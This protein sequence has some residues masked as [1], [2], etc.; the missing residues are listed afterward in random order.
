[1]AAIAITLAGCHSYDR[2]AT[3]PSA[4][5][6]YAVAPH[7]AAYVHTGATLP[8]AELQAAKAATARYRDF[9]NALKDGYQDINVVIPNMGR[10]FLNNGLLDGKFE[11]D[12]PELLVYSPAA[13]GRMELV[14]VEYAVPLDLSATA[15]EGF[16]GSADEWF[17][18][19]QFQLWTLHAWVWKDNPDGVFNPTNSR[20]P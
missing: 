18:N 12:K 19:Q 6:G 3:G 10:H 8:H 16:T 15:P 1:M 13:N 4:T 5:S 7:H 9:N 2:T 17:A 14:A 11:A 20:V